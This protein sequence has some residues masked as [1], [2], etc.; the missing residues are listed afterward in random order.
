MTPATRLQRAAPL[1]E[2][3]RHL[4]TSAGVPI[5]VPLTITNQA[6]EPRVF[7]VSALGVDTTWVPDAD[8]ERRRRAG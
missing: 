5:G 3:V 2:T 7:V 1:V 4:R 8:A 6:A